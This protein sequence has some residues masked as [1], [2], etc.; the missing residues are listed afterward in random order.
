MRSK[1]RR[2][3]GA[4]RIGNSHSGNQASVLHVFRNE[5]LAPGHQS[6]GNQQSVPPL[7][8]G[9]ILNCP[10][11]NG[12][13]RVKRRNAPRNEKREKGLRRF[14]WNKA[15]PLR[16]NAVAFIQIL[17]AQGQGVIADR[18]PQQIR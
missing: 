7:Q 15:P 9:F 4:E 8:A 14:L 18:L 3:F 6:R 5:Q 2:K 11:L 10:C 17:G 16:E 1:A 13:L 12:R